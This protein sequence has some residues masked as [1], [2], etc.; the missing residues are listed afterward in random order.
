M[1]APTDLGAGALLRRSIALL[2]SFP[3]PLLLPTVLLGLLSGGGGFQGGPRGHDAFDPAVF[4]PLSAVPFYVLVAAIAAAV[5]VALV[6][7][8]IIV[9]IL[10]V[11]TALVYTATSRAVLDH[12][13]TGTA[14][15]FGASF[16]ATRARWGANALT[17]LL[18]A[19]VVILGF[20]ALIVPGVILLSGFL[21]LFAVLASETRGGSDA[22]RRA[23]EVSKGHKTSLAALVVAGI[24]VEIVVGAGLGGIPFLGWLASGIA[25]GAVSAVWLVSGAILYRAR[26]AAGGAAGPLA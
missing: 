17:L 25:S 13:E 4:D 2:R 8:A 26:T 6:L 22:L 21:P 7:V 19:V 5:V 24:V 11:A 23:W 1:D 16:R 9:A 10:L 14:P 3:A 18:A 15:D 12:L 20:I